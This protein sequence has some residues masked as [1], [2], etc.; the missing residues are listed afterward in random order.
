MSSTESS[1]GGELLVEEDDVEDDAIYSSF[2]SIYAVSLDTSLDVDE[3][4]APL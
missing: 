3:A 1:V 2:G 4:I